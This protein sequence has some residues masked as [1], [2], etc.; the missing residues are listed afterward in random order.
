MLKAVVEA[1]HV[2]LQAL[3][4]VTVVLVAVVILSQFIPED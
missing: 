4:M 1:K 3:R 2:H